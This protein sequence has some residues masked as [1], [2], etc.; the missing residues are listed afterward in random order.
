[1]ELDAESDLL[2]ESIDRGGGK[3]MFL[4]SD[5][6]LTADLYHITGGGG[7]VS[8]SIQPLKAAAAEPIVDTI[9]PGDDNLESCCQSQ[10][11]SLCSL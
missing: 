6:S 5:T 11:K 2:G 4:I 10:Q 1:M 7:A 9:M 3:W 8:A